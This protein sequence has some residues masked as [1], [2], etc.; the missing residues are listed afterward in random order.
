M[1]TPFSV[2]NQ[3]WTESWV[4]DFW[5]TWTPCKLDRRY[6]LRER[7]H[8]LLIRGKIHSL[9]V[10]RFGHCMLVMGNRHPLL[11]EAIRDSLL[12]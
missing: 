6:L 9:L 12:V 3:P 11:V 7:M 2:S 8:S 10:K 5:L 4:R 1:Y